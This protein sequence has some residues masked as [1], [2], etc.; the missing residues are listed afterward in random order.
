MSDDANAQKV[1]SVY[2]R[3]AAR[4][5]ATAHKTKT[6]GG[7]GLTYVD[8]ETVI[9]RLNEELGLDGWSFEVK[10]ITVLEDEVW[11]QG[12]L[13]VYLGD[14]TI[15][16]EQAGGQIIKRKRG[17]PAVPARPAQE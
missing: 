11:A 10:G 1:P 9:L 2:S 17:M 15:V 7:T 14:R 8:G 4:F 3:L 5:P 12:R 16:R 6:I 13:T